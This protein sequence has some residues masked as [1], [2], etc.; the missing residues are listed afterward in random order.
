M[1]L[2]FVVFQKKT[3]VLYSALFG[4]NVINIKLVSKFWIIK[5]FVCMNLTLKCVYAY[6]FLEM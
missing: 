6:L 3:I 4:C 1:T 2:N 5:L